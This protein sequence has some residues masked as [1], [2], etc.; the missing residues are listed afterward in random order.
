MTDDARFDLKNDLVLLEK[1]GRLATITINRPRKLNALNLD[2]MNEF[3]QVLEALR[4]DDEISVVIITGA[5][6]CFSAGADLEFL[7]SLGTP[8]RFRTVLKEYWHRNFDAIESMEKLFIAAINGPAIGGA[9]EMALACDLRVAAESTTI[10]LPEI[11][12]GLIPDSGGTNRLARQIGLAQAK[13]LVFSAESIGSSEAIR[14][15]LVNKVF[16]DDG[17]IQAVKTYAQK[18]LDKSP[19]ALGLGKLAIN[20]SLDLDTRAGLDDAAMVQ[21]LLLSSE[22]YQQAIRVFLVKSA[23]RHHPKPKE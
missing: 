13:E 11:R 4:R 10:S 15:G 16:P 6:K 8:E 9:V 2:L 7:H 20:R 23:G 18:F 12:Y 1:E 5:G 17:F 3:G 21:S 22:E 14:L 19:A